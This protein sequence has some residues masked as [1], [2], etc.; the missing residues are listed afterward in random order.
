MTHSQKAEMMVQQTEK[1]VMRYGLA[2]AADWNG[3]KW[4]P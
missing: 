2:A 1:Y 3:S 4:I